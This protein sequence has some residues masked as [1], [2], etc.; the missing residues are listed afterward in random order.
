M[1]P[2]EELRFLILGA[3]REGNRVLAGLLAPLGLTPSQA[4][5]IGCL[6]QGGEMS[7]RDLGSLLVCE[8]G[9]PSR[10]VDTLV[11]RGIV[12]RR[13]DARDRRHV[14]LHLSAE[15][16]RLAEDIKAVEANLYDWLVQRLDAQSL[17]ALIEPLR[18]VLEGS[19][20]GDAIKRRRSGLR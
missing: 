2:E 9:S 17:A 16:R 12:E 20:A 14:T 11:Q 19:S 18:G 8:S 3:Q 5:V 15:G 1:R 7:L 4:E 13:A 10:L 6:N